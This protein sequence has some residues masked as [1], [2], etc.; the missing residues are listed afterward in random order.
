MERRGSHGFH[1]DDPD[2]GVCLLYR[3]GDSGDE[4]P[5]SHGD[6]NIGYIRQL[7]QDLQTDGPLSGHDQRVIE[8]VDEEHPPLS[9]RGAG[10]LVRFIEIPPHKNHL[11]PQI[12]GLEDLEERR[13]LRHV[14]DCRDAEEVGGVGHPLGMIAGGSGDDTPLQSL[15]GVTRHEVH[16]PPDLEGTGP[17]KI[18]A[19]EEERE[20]E[21]SA[22]VVRVDQLGA[23]D[24]LPEP[25][26]RFQD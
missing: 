19:L 12:A 20:T 21:T 11:C 15:P 13:L 3:R 5:S 26:G 8:G 10:R 1:G 25:F 2:M 22:E 17:L 18:L 14:D 24:P 16:C 6:E 4:P 9:L 7:F 23:A